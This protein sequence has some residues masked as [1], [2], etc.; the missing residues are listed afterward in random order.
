LGIQ[1]AAGLKTRFIFNPKSGHNARNPHLLHR[2]RA[3]I[4]EHQ[5]DAEVVATTHPL[6]ATELAR[7][8]V[9]QGCGT[10]VAIGG[11]GT[12]NEVA[13]AL[14]GTPATLG[15][16]PCGSGN[17]LGRYLGIPG[18]GRGAFA[19]LLRGR[20]RTIDTG[21]ANGRAFF[22][23]MG[24]GFD[25][26]IS[27][28]FAH[29]SRRG[30]SA[31]VRTT[32]SAWRSYQPPEVIIRA[33]GQ[34]LRERAFI[35]SVANSDQFGNDCFIAPEAKVDDGQ[36]N[37]TVLRPVNLLQAV[38][39]GWRLFRRS[40]HRSPHAVTLAAS[41]FVISRAAPG[42]IHTDGEP[43]ATDAEVTVE[44]KPASL[45]VLVPAGD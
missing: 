23:V 36:L 33:A 24:L 1:P 15:L 32:L 25:A 22:N 27:D 8:A 17:G 10:V 20:V 5:L 44:V 12:M 43:F 40:V 21:T 2:A 28:R 18:P 37:L 13:A 38:P 3:F 29:V 6:H 39:L 30:F 19:N 34:E 45:R 26:E 9:A 35:L 7:E 4:R 16:I 14:V 11:D 31:Y 41:R 42:L